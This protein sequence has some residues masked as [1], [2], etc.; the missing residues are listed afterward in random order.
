M[1][2]K[3]RRVIVADDEMIM[4]Q[5]LK[6]I[7]DEGQFEVVAEATHGDEIL[8]KCLKH[9]PDILCLDINMPRRDGVEALKDIRA[10]LPDLQVLMISGNTASDKVKQA[11]SLGAVG[12]IVKPFNAA[13]VLQRL[14]QLFGEAQ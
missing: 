11:I 2:G 1:A 5:V 12:F 8:A 13:Q 7:L 14:L 3:G 9:R 10:Q 6:A 4:R